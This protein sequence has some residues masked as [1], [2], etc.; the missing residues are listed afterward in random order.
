MSDLAAAAAA[1]GIPEALV[2]RSAEA[3]AKA[4]GASVDEIL[5]A[6]AGGGT[7]PAPTPSPQPEVSPPEP[8][9]S[10]SPPEPEPSVSPPEG[11][12]T[13]GAGEGGTPAP[14]MPV[15]AAPEPSEVNPKEALRYPAVVTVPTSGLVERTVGAIP[16]WLAAAFF[17]LP[18]FGLIQLASATSNDC[19][20]GTELAVDRVTGTVENCDGSPFEGRGTPGGSV[21]FVG[22]G[23]QIFA[24]EVVT[25]ANCAGCHGPQGQGGVGPPLGGVLGTFSSC[26]DHIDWVAKG[27]AGFQAE[28]ASTYGDTG[29][30]INGGMPGFAGSLSAEQIAAVA[31]FERVRLGAGD[32]ATVLADCGL[33]AAEAPAEGEVP[34]EEGGA[35]TAPAT[36]AA[37]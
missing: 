19:G 31:A 12:S 28:G 13:G 16:R 24:G 34:A 11:G 17:I 35:T 14:S 27:S 3:R 4:S 15:V 26:V 33:V 6:W 37:P 21:D 36:T 7:A 18:L 20:S 23:A 32:P 5:A 25:A 22:L 29:K 1:L 8:V 30:P 9:P 2:Q 10:A